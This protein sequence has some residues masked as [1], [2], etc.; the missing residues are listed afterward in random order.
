MVLVFSLTEK[1]APASKTATSRRRISSSRGIRFN[2][3]Q[4]RLRPLRI[5]DDELFNSDEE[6]LTIG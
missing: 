2:Q 4:G 6:T 1:G 5:E 3:G